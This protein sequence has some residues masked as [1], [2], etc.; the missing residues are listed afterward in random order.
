[1]NDSNW[2]EDY[3]KW[4]ILKPS[5]IQLLDEGAESLS[6]TWLLNAM[7]CEWKEIKKIKEAEL[8]SLQVMPVEPLLPS[9]SVLQRELHNDPWD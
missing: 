1:M 3:K 7:W 5:Q 9:E 4:K 8:P 6:Q 2:K